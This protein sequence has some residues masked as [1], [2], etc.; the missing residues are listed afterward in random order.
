MDWNRKLKQLMG[1]ATHLVRTGQLAQATQAI[2][3]ALRQPANAGLTPSA[4]PR[5]EAD[6]AEPAVAPAATRFTF[7]PGARWPG[8]ETAQVEDA[9]IV[10]RP[11]R[12]ASYPPS[13][14]R[15]CRPHPGRG[16]IQPRRLP[17]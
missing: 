10:E 3:Q 8:A 9:V 5:A 7:T 1:D 15:R 14:S 2:Q 16:H 4:A 12:H 13:T 6:V 11:A 17:P